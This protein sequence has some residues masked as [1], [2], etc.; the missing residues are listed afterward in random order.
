LIEHIFEKLI[1]KKAE[2]FCKSR[3]GPKI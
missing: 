1:Y 3:L 2:G